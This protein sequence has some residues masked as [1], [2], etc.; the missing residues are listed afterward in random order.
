MGL[1]DSLISSV[2]PYAPKPLVKVFAKRYIAG[3]TLNDAMNT[4]ARLNAEGAMATVDALGEFVKSAEVARHEAETSVEVLHEIARR[5]VDSN[6]SV[7]L[8][9]LGLDIDAD[10]A[11]DNL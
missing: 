5:G 7:K 11:H 10:F 4:A 3:D 2:L 8:T 1:F 6:L 9:S